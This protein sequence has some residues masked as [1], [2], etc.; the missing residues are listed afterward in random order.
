MPDACSFS[1]SIYTDRFLTSAFRQLDISK[2][3]IKKMGLLL[4]YTFYILLLHVECN[5]NAS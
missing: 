4:Q 5:I 2:D 1:H 3:F